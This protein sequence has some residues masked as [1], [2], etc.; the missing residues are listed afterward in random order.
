MSECTVEE[1]PSVPTLK[2]TAKRRK[3]CVRVVDKRLS[4]PMYKRRG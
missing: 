2:K 1:S 4:E 3:L